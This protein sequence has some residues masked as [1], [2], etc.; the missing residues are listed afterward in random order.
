[1]LIKCFVDN[2]ICIVTTI[3]YFILKSSGKIII[4]YVSRVVPVLNGVVLTWIPKR[5][6]SVN[7]LS[8]SKLSHV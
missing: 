1:M 3:S 4:I 8:G 2:K 7:V 5:L 6:F